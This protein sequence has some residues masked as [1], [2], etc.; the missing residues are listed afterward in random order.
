[1]QDRVWPMVGL[2]WTLGCIVMISKNVISNPSCKAIF[3]VVLLKVLIA[4]DCPLL[5]ALTGFLLLRLDRRTV[6]R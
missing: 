5:K 2:Y 1:M 6:R 3:L 4:M